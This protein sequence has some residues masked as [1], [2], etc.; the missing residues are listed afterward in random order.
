MNIAI[1]HLS[2]VY[3][4]GTRALDDVNIE[5]EDG[6]YALIGL[7]AS[8]K[9]T[10]M[11]I[12]ATLLE[13]TGGHVRF[14]G[15]DLAKNRAE[16]RAMTGYLPQKF[17]T[18]SNLS[19]QDVLDYCARLSGL[20]S[21]RDRNDAVSDM[22]ESLG[23]AAVRK[24]NAND[25]SHIQKRHLEI[26]QAMI[27]NPRIILMDEPTAGL[28]PEER[29]RFRKLLIERSKTAE[30]TL[31]ATHILT[32]I[33]SHCSNVAILDKGSLV[34]FGKPDDALTYIESRG[35]PTV[36]PKE[37]QKPEEAKKVSL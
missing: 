3:D 28:S 35:W 2:K 18:F 22:M 13:P 12:L 7:N 5:L 23:L 20:R 32:D 1:E 25:L 34:H 21:R 31:F 36:F 30:I 24:K 10:L 11:R 26:A 14:N 29:I 17:S 4:N 19:A 37:K 6:L 8:G 15:Y 27:G 9:S 16:I 33:A